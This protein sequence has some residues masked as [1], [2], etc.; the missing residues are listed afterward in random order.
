MKEFTLP[1]DVEMPLEEHL[2]ELGRRFLFT[3]AVIAALTFLIFPFSGSMIKVLREDLLPPGAE[4]RIEHPTE[5]LYTRIEVS[6]ISAFLL[7]LSLIIYE[8]FVFMKPGLYPSERKF[9]VRVMPGSIILLFLGAFFSYFVVTPF[10]VSRLYQYSESTVLVLPTLKEFVSFAY[11]M[12]LIFGMIFQMPLVVSFLVMGNLVTIRQLTEKRKI[13]YALLLF[14]GVVIAPDPTPLTPLI[15]A[16]A[17]VVMY[18]IS[19]IF[20][21]AFVRG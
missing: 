1:E 17:L 18:E 7:V 4:L 3:A 14:G 10:F 13:A 19:I 12:L 8:L 11:S 16:A 20:A 2:V 9:F 15:V 5:Y 6:I 21:K